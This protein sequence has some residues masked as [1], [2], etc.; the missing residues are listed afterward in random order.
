MRPWATWCRD[1]RTRSSVSTTAET[2]LAPF[3]H[4]PPGDSGGAGGDAVRAGGDAVR[5]GR[6]LGGSHTLYLCAPA[7]DQRR[8]RGY[9]TVL[10][11]QVLAAVFERATRSGR[12]LDPPLLVVLDEAAHIA[13]LREARRP[14][15]HVRLA[16][17][18]AG[19]RVAGPGPGPRALRHARADGAEQPP[20]QAVPAGDRRSRHARVRQPPR[21]RRGGDAAVG[22]PRPGGPALHHLV[23]G[24]ATAAAAQ[25]LRGLLLAVASSS[26]APCRRPDCSCGRGGRR[27]GR[28]E[29][30]GPPPHATAQLVGSPRRLDRSNPESVASPARGFQQI[31]R[32]SKY[33]QPGW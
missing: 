10:T 20:G 27:A 26:T 16:R 15:G 19:H 28:G 2:V 30:A 33:V 13:P 22:H 29:G 3:A 1:E 9:F 7:H 25:E 4:A 12:P 6:P 23:H 11:E 32:G 14:G 8:L 17:H 21:G 18:S 31:R 5:A 24:A